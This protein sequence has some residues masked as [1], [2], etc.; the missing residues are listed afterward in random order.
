MKHL[1]IYADASGESHFE[2]MDV[3]MRSVNF[4]PGAEAVDLSAIQPAAGYGFI[5]GP[6]GWAGGWNPSPQRMLTIVLQGEVEV[7]ASDGEVRRLGPGAVVLN[8]DLTGRGHRS[9]VVSADSLVMAIVPA[10]IA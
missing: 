1:R 2:E 9:T 8:D 5:V 6:S 4:V 10:P 7:E 3:P